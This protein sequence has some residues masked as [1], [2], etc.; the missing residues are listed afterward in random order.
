MY[1]PLSAW[2]DQLDRNSLI[3]ST[4]LPA[5]QRAAALFRLGEFERAESLL[6]A[7]LADLS[8]SQQS[9]PLALLAWMRLENF[10]ISGFQS[11]FQTLQRNWPDRPEVRSLLFKFLLSTNRGHSIVSSPSEWVSLPDKQLRLT[12]Q[13]LHA[14]WLI[15]SGR[16]PEARTWLEPSLQGQSLEA[17]ILAARC[18]KSQGDLLKALVLLRHS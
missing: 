17:S 8:H 3:Q 4:E 15:V 16:V 14:E 9:S 5:D 12:F 1:L 18:D 6:I 13:L 10:D 11:V 7:H 2:P